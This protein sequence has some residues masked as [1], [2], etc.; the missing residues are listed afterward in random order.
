MKLVRT[1]L[2][3]ASLV[4]LSGLASAADAPHGPVSAKLAT[5]SAPL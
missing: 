2:L 3:A 1:V 4:S 5:P